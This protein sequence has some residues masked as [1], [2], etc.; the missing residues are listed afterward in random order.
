M[1]HAWYTRDISE[2]RVWRRAGAVVWS[3]ALFVLFGLSYLTLTNVTNI[4][5]LFSTREW[6]TRFGLAIAFALTQLPP[7]VLAT[8]LLRPA[9]APLRIAGGPVGGGVDPFGVFAPPGSEARWSGARA[10]PHLFPTGFQQSRW[11]QHIPPNVSPEEIA[12][13]TLGSVAL[14]L[15]HL[16]S[17]AAGCALFA[18]AAHD[19]CCD[20]RGDESGGGHGGHGHEHHDHSGH[21]HEGH[22]HSPHDDDRISVWGLVSMSPCVAR[23]A[24]YGAALGAAAVVEYFFSGARQASFAHAPRPRVYRVKA[25]VPHCA[26]SGAV[27]ACY[28]VLLATAVAALFPLEGVVEGTLRDDGLTGENVEHVAEVFSLKRFALVPFH[29]LKATVTFAYLLLVSFLGNL[30]YAPLG[31]VV[32]GCWFVS[33][34]A[35]EIVQTERYRFLPQSVRFGK[36]IGKYF[37]FTTF[38]LP[39]CLYETDTFFFI[40][41][42]SAPLLASLVGD[43]DAWTQHLAFMDLCFV[44]ELGGDGRRELLL[45]DPL[46]TTSDANESAFTPTLAAALAPV[47]AVTSAMRA[48]LAAA[49]TMERLNVGGGVNFLTGKGNVGAAG[50]GVG[51]VRLRA[52]AAGGTFGGSVASTVGGHGQNGVFEKSVGGFGGNDFVDRRR[53][54][55][56]ASDPGSVRETTA[57]NSTVGRVTTTAGRRVNDAAWAATAD[58]WGMPASVVDGREN[59]DNGVSHSEHDSQGYVSGKLSGDQHESGKAN[60]TQATRAASQVTSGFVEDA[61]VGHTMSSRRHA[62]HAESLNK[63]R[64]QMETPTQ[65]ASREALAV[66][67]A[68]GQLAVWGCRAATALCLADLRTGGGAGFDVGVDGDSNSKASLIAAPQVLRV[69]LAALKTAESCAAAGVGGGSNPANP[70]GYLPGL[71]MRVSINPRVPELK[72]ARPAAAT[73]ASAFRSAT[74]A[75]CEA[76][77]AAEARRMMGGTERKGQGAGSIPGGGDDTTGSQVAEDTTPKELTDLLESVLRWE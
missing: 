74:R 69:L 28:A 77:G 26:Y 3:F 42:A 7:A 53:T 60:S 73:L 54:H 61:I 14:V 22:H 38:H 6:A 24:R 52:A 51:G 57:M 39:D 70:A 46:S 27:L 9:V 17:G 56:S 25:C 15:A 21:M 29:V 23:A 18:D 50:G 19:R 36:T 35:A 72:D 47:L 37:S 30:G 64:A 48:V 68:H 10:P 41:S 71:R 67:A 4:G 34:A 5:A 76:V 59:T 33:R 44:C 43:D 31:A 55:Q 45:R 66:L 2:M 63:L 32:C 75:F 40:V 12:K 11:V 58:E 13:D 20:H 62:E 49:E 65:A 1:D 8:V 16:V